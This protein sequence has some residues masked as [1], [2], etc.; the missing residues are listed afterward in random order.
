MQG[1]THEGG[2]GDTSK[3]K[4]VHQNSFAFV[5]LLLGSAAF[6][7]ARKATIFSYLLFFQL[8]IKQLGKTKLVSVV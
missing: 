1:R 5:C 8:S 6:S 7:N 3:E 2:I 4:A